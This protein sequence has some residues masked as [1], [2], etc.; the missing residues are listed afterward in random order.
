MSYTHTFYAVDLERLR[1]LWG[2]ADDAFVEEV[3]SAQAEEIE[4]NDAFFEDA[5]DEDDCPDTAQAIRDLLAGKIS[6]EKGAEAMYGYTL[7]ILCAQLGTFAECDDVYDVGLHPYRSK[8][9]GSGPPLPI[10]VDPSDLPEVA[11][12]DHADLADEIRSLDAGPRRAKKSVRLSLL[13]KLTG[14][15]I[16]KQMDD[17]EVAQDMRAYRDALTFAQQKGLSLVSLRH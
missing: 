5:I 8:L 11:Y 10:P 17:D 2:S 9:A 13:S 12:L 14:G 6:Q 1:D 3:L 7:G 15:L 4:D 16:G